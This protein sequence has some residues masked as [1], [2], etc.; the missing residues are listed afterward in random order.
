MV[1]MM[2]LPLSVVLLATSGYLHAQS[3]QLTQDPNKCSVGLRNH[4]D[5]RC[6]SSNAKFL[7]FSG[8]SFTCKGYNSQNLLTYITLNMMDGLS[9]WTMHGIAAVG[10]DKA[11]H[12]RFDELLIS[13]VMR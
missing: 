10:N 9:L 12:I 5:S 8:C 4:I 3:V 13:E 11:C 1:R 6:A 7:S 2:I